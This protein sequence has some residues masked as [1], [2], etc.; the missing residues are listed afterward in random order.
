MGWLEVW[1]RGMRMEMGQ[2]CKDLQPIYLCLT[3]C[4]LPWYR[5]YRTMYTESL[6][7]ICHW[8]PLCWHN[9]QMTVRAMLAG[10][11]DIH[12]HSSM[13]F[14]GW[15]MYCHCQTSNLPA[16]E[17][18]DGPVIQHHPSRRQTG[19]FVASGLHLDKNRIIL[20]WPLKEHVLLTPQIWATNV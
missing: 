1:A 3:E 14:H 20:Q 16:T 11:Q 18:Y 15:F 6:A 13:N 4:T 5:Y 19:H 10:T 8:P 17:K 2:K 7:R 12:G 9:G